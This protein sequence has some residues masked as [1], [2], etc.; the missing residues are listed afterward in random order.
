MFTQRGKA[1]GCPFCGRAE[2]AWTLSPLAG[3]TS[4]EV[5]TAC[6]Q[7]F[8]VDGLLGKARWYLE[9]AKRTVETL[10]GSKEGRPPSSSGD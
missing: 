5:R 10:D 2:C 7:A 6:G 1:S 4:A 3:P 8:S 9:A